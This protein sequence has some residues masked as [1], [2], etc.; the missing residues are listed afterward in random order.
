M[1]R[2][3]DPC[4]VSIAAIVLKDGG[5]GNQAADEGVVHQDVPEITFA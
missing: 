4:H 5:G 2:I 3:V 1:V